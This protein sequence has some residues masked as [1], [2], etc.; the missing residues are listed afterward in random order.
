VGGRASVSF[1]DM[2]RLDCE[3]VGRASL[4]TDL[5]I[6]LRTVPAVVRGRGAN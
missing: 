2:L 5:M 6:L 1:Q 4:R 3:Y